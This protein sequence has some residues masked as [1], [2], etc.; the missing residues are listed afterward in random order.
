[1]S[2]L[3]LLMPFYLQNVRSFSSLTVGFVMTAIPITMFIVAP[4]AG[5]LADAYGSRVLAVLGSSLIAAALLLMGSAWGGAFAQPTL[6]Q[7]IANVVAHLCLMGA[8]FGIFQS[9]NSKAVLSDVETD[10]L[11]MASAL[12]ATVRNLGLVT[13][14]AL[15][16]MLLMSFYRS[17][18]ADHALATS[19]ENFVLALRETF[20][21]IGALTCLAIPASAFIA[22]ASARAR[23]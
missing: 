4:I 10:N 15:S 1:M 3:M 13:G 18:A 14:T 5:R 9:P 6:E 12:L 23:T 17:A 22:P 21:F 7:S 16:S 19:G 2:S 8:G 11:G 20:Y